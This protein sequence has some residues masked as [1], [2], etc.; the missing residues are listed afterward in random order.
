MCVC[1]ARDKSNGVTVASWGA[2]RTHIS[3]ACAIRATALPL[4]HGARGR[5]PSSTASP[6]SWHSHGHQATNTAQDLRQNPRWPSPSGR[7]V[8][9]FTVACCRPDIPPPPRPRRLRG[10]P[11]V[12]SPPPCWIPSRHAGTPNH[13]P[14]W[15]YIPR[16]FQPRFS[17]ITR[18][19]ILNLTLRDIQNP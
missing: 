6:R 4:H 19:F 8:A 14:P 16:R 5:T 7:C 12:P 10:Q 9:V 2:W 11:A 15:P 13:R 17:R 3:M 1:V 18:R